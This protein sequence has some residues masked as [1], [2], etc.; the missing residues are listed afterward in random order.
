MKQQLYEHNKKIEAKKQEEEFA[1]IYCIP[2]S[3]PEKISFSIKD[4]VNITHN[5][6]PYSARKYEKGTYLDCNN[7]AESDCISNI[8]VTPMESE[9]FWDEF[10][11]KI[12]VPKEIVTKKDGQILIKFFPY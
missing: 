6:F 1:K 2:L 5:F 12:E 4:P 11:E 10:G 3:M 8:I 9:Y 7:L